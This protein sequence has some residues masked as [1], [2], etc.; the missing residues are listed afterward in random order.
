[1]RKKNLIAAMLLLS[2]GFIL[3][4]PAHKTIAEVLRDSNHY[5]DRDVTV[6]GRVTHSYGVL[7]VGAYQIDD[8][9]GKLWVL[10]EGGR[11]IPPDGS[12]VGVTGRIVPTMT[13][14]GRS[15]ATILRE[16]KRHN[17]RY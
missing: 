3:G 14:G 2:L 17:T 10:A 13:I 1:M 15:F 5:A 9:T 4:C 11:N 16:N 7:G 12:V 8:G 6:G